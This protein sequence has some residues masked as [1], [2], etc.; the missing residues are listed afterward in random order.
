MP[1]SL[2]HLLHDNW[3]TQRTPGALDGHS[4]CARSYQS[5]RRESGWFGGFCVMQWVKDVLLLPLSNHFATLSIAPDTKDSIHIFETDSHAANGRDTSMNKTLKILTPRLKCWE[6]ALLKHSVVAFA[7]SP[8]LLNLKVELQ[9]T[10]TAEVK[11]V[12]ALLDSGMN[13]LFIDSDF[14]RMQKL[15]LW[16]LTCPTPVFNVDSTPNEAGAI[17]YITDVILRFWDH[18]ECAVFAAT[19]L[20]K[21][22]MSLGYPWLCKHNPEVNWQTQEII[23]SHC[24][25]Q[26]HTCWAK[27]EIEDPY[28]LHVPYDPDGGRWRGRLGA[29]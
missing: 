1:S 26:C 4:R 23:L 10:D 20:G 24:P 5:G 15:T 8:N 3:I 28:L 22:K 16:P 19:N 7:T 18:S 11:G 12:M 14:A 2:W 27:G 25:A 9:T 6:W 21:H 29:G 17:H 13:G